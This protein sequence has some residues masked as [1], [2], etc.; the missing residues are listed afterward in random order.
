[1]KLST[2]M[3]VVKLKLSVKLKSISSEHDVLV[4]RLIARWMLD[5]QR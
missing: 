5:S 1:M 2:V 3:V 4:S